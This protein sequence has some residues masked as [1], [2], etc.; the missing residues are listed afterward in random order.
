[1]L[2]ALAVPLLTQGFLWGPP[3]GDG[4]LIVACSSYDWAVINP[5]CQ[6]LS[7]ESVLVGFFISETQAVHPCCFI[8][9]GRLQNHLLDKGK[10]LWKAK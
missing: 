7:C 1:M 5:E 9:W 10:S 8:S 4:V 6:Q 2:G 3:L